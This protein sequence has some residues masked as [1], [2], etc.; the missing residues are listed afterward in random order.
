MQ[1]RC[2]QRSAIT[3][4]PGGLA[5]GKIHR[6]TE[7]GYT[8]AQPCSV[9]YSHHADYAGRRCGREHGDF[10]RGGGCASETAALPSCRAVDRGV[11]YCAGDQHQGPEHVSV[12]LFHRS[13]TEH[14]AT[15]Y[16]R[17][18]WRLAE[19]DRRGRTGTCAGARRY[20]R[21]TADTGCDPGAGTFIHTPG[22]FAWSAPDR[23][24]LLC[25]LAAEVWRRIV[26]HR[27]PHHCG[28]KDA[29][30]H[31]RSAQGISLPRSAGCRAGAALP[32]GS[33]QGQTGQ[34]QPTR[35]CQV[36]AWS[37]HGA[38]Q[39]RHGPAAA[40]YFSQFSGARG[41]QPHHL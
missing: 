32:M 41:L 18:R 28:W 24:P 14:H 30:N 11:A 22:R 33:Q 35:L 12:D 31:R 19:R 29:A 25:I 17:L 38:S 2:R 4:F 8:Q 26:R 27:A 39:R 7:A 20:R 16:R 5:H 10:Q 15:G 23:A 1:D 21:R 9:V 40:H 13:R 34:L 36:E 37:H 3:S 6:S